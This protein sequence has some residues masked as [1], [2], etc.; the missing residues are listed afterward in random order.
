MLDAVERFGSVDASDA[1]GDVEATPQQWREAAGAAVPRLP[2]A[3]FDAVLIA[4]MGGSG[5]AGDV[6]AVLAAPVAALPVVVHKGYGAPA[7]VGPRT[8]V[9]ALS[10]SG[11]T[12][13]TL[14]TVATAADRGASIVAITAGG[15][16]A[17]RSEASGWRRLAMPPGRQPRHSLG[18]LAV[19]VLRLL[20]LDDDLDE[21]ITVQEDL[22]RACARIVPSS[23]NPAKQLGMRIASGTLTLIYG[24]GPLP[25]P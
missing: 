3:D 24:A 6:A 13:E 14:S 4:G 7:F 2:L 10:Y 12:E 22:V 9:V 15:E 16:L 1:L 23:D 20:G 21:A 25:A 18:Y 5:I 17:R 11:D 19:P 8:L